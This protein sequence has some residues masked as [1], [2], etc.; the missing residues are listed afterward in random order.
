MRF[1]YGLVVAIL[2]AIAISKIL[3]GGAVQPGP[4]SAAEYHSAN[5]TGSPIGWTIADTKLLF[6]ANRYPCGFV[7]NAEFDFDEVT[8]VSAGTTH[9]SIFSGAGDRIL[10]PKG[11]YLARHAAADYLWCDLGN[12]KVTGVTTKPGE[13]INIRNIFVSKNGIVTEYLTITRAV[14][15]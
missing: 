1:I 8:E 4:G 5:A 14:N 15:P 2:V 10:T 13:R 7:T 12:I 6:E 3:F 9:G 11:R